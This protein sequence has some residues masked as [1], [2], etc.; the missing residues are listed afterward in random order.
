MHVGAER[1]HDE[2]HGDTTVVFKKTKKY[3]TNVLVLVRGVIVM[4]SLT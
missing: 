1:F 4:N 2:F 3:M